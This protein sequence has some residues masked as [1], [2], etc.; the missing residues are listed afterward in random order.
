MVLQGLRAVDRLCA[1]NLGGV[2]AEAILAAL[3]VEARFVALAVCGPGRPEGIDANATDA[4]ETLR[5]RHTI[6]GDPDLARALGEG[7]SAGEDL[8][9]LWERIILPLAPLDSS[10]G[11][12]LLADTMV[13]ALS[14]AV[15]GS[16]PA[17][18]ADVA[19]VAQGR[20][21]TTWL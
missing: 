4:E 10:G 5:Y 1:E 20:T 9:G 8:P 15:S 13:A 16:L 17:A 18:V 12:D 7:L 11:L 19:D 14:L 2:E 3:P 6:M 21:E